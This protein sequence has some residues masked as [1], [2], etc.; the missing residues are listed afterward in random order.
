MNHQQNFFSPGTFI[1]VFTV[2]SSS[3]F[4]EAQQE[5][6]G[7]IRA[8]GVVLQG[9]GLALVLLQASFY[10]RTAALSEFAGMR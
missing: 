8:Q 4:A 6:A 5:T 1:R 9:L 2:S 3:A 7:R 10:L